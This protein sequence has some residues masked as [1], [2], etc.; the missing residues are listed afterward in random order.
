MELYRGLTYSIAYRLV[1]SIKW[2][3]MVNSRLMIFDRHLIFNFPLA[4]LY[5]NS[6]LSSLNARSSLSGGTTVSE[7]QVAQNKSPHT[8]R[9][10]SPHLRQKLYTYSPRSFQGPD[11]MI[12]FTNSVR[13]EVY[14]DVESHELSDRIDSKGDVTMYEG[15]PQSYHSGPKENAV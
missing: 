6:L 12:S 11:Q 10:V 8:G 3:P 9:V 14:I 15:S 1:S 4:K 13:P 2:R 5:S 7:N